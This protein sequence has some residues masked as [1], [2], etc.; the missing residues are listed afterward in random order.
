MWDDRTWDASETDHHPRRPI[1][2]KI[3]RTKKFPQ[4][5]NQPPVDPTYE[6]YSTVF[7]GTVPGMGYLRTPPIKF[8]FDS[9]F[10]QLTKSST[11][12]PVDG[13]ERRWPI[14]EKQQSTFLLDL[15]YVSIS[16]CL[17]DFVSFAVQS[18][19]WRSSGRPARAKHNSG[20]TTPSLPAISTTADVSTL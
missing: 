3:L 19:T 10:A 4:N 13:R 16:M 2:Q 7:K 9:R 15:F 18:A 12:E 8:S 17:F 1:F 20:V 11:I 5:L 14:D 6:K